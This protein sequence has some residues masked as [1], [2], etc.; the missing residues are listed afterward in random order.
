[1]AVKRAAKTG[2]KKLFR[3]P[4]SGGGKKRHG[5][6]VVGGGVG[7]GRF[8]VRA[9]GDGLKMGNLAPRKEKKISRLYFF[10]IF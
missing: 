4:V 2:E 8:C 6:V 7:C 3:N 1:L 5:G 10:D 9:C